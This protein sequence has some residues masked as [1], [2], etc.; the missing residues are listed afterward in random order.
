MRPGLSVL[1]VLRLVTAPIVSIED[2]LRRMDEL[3]M[4]GIAE[5]GGVPPRRH[6]PYS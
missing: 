5:W 6:P 4:H 1:D 2:G 3:G